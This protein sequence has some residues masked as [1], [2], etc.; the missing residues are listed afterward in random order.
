[1]YEHRDDKQLNTCAMNVLVSFYIRLRSKIYTVG[2]PRVS[3]TGVS[4]VS[5]EI[6]YVRPKVEGWCILSCV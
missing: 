3:G 2:W 4:S 1:M 5:N 6:S